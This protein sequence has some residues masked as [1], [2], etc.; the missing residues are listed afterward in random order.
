MLPLTTPT[1]RIVTTGPTATPA[2][3]TVVGGTAVSVLGRSYQGYPEIGGSVRFA[4]C[5]DGARTA[6][7]E[8]AIVE[9]SARYPN[10]TVENDVGDAATMRERLVTALASGTPPNAVMLAAD[11]TAYFAEQGALLPL[12]SRLGRDGIDAAWFRPEELRARSWQ[13]QTYGLPQTTNGANALLF[14]NLRLLDRIGIDRTV[15]IRTWRDLAMLAEPARQA[16]LIALNP[17]Q[18][19]GSVTGHQIWT[20]ANGGRYWD[21]DLQ[22]V[23]WT[24]P[25]SVEAAAWLVQLVRAQAGEYAHLT[26]GVPGG[27]AMSA[28]AWADERA[29]CCV[30][31]AG[32]IFELEQQGKPLE[33]AVYALPR[34][35]NNPE[36]HGAA[37]TAGGWSLAI[38]KRARDQDAAWEWLKH[39]ALSE[40]A[41]TFTARQHRPSPLAGCDDR[42]DLAA[43]QPFWP[44]IGAS[45]TMGVRV[46][47]TPI[48]PRL[49]RI[50][51]AMQ[52][53]IL[54]ERTP[55]ADALHA[56]ARD[57]QRLLDAWNANGRHS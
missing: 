52:D 13:G 50:A 37:P 57:A 55:P 31:D 33:Y 53:E 24:E 17:A 1:P 2:A 20:Y 43:T 5:W 49:E 4:N 27:T 12:D 36:S 6:L 19:G 3:S 42:P 11:S 35:G 46:P 16:R 28:T 41:C 21:D 44:E 51:R 39:A 29:V 10:V 9:F 30:N 48:Q 45:L 26:G 8:S 40:S 38:P 56:A 7:V 18:I 22:H 14:V 54:S 47:A 23:A 15:P 25:A 34:N 32:W